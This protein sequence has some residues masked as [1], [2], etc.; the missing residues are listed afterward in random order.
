M[1]STTL[2][3]IVGGAAIT[4]ATT[5]AL[6]FAMPATASAATATAPVLKASVSGGDVTFTLDDPNTGI[7]D[8]CAAGLVD[9]GRAVEI[10]ALLANITDPANFL[11][12]LNSGVIKGAPA[13]TTILDRSASV[14]VQDLPNGVYAAVGA[15]AGIGKDAA[16]A[17]APVIVPAGLGSVAGVADFGSTVLENPESIPVFLTLLGVSSASSGDSGSAGS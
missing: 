2:T 13:I 14:T 17:M 16:T 7:L 11:G 1:P 5:A 9:A 3:R 8:G 4:A 6:A 15:C 12:I 10:S